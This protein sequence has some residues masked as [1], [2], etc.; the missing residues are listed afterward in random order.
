[1]QVTVTLC[2]MDTWLLQQIVELVTLSLQATFTQIEVKLT[3]AK[4][5]SVFLLSLGICFFF[6]MVSFVR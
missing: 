2:S 6:G 5:L 1:M 3:K 4:D